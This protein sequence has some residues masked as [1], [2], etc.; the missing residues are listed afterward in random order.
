[1]LA[2]VPRESKITDLSDD[3]LDQFVHGEGNV[4]MDREHLS[5]R[6]LVQRRLHVSIQH[7]AHHLQKGRVVVFNV[8]VHWVEGEGEKTENKA[9]YQRRWVVTNH[10]STQSDY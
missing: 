3:A 2:N 10:G 5:Q 6:V 8:D 1:M 7:A 9:F 4:G